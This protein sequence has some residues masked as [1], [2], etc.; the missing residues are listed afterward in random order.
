MRRRI[1]KAQDRLLAQGRAIT[2][3]TPAEEVHEL[4][5]D[6]KKLRY[7]LEC[8]GGLLPAAERKAFVKRLKE[9]QDN[10]GEHQDAAVHVAQ[11]HEAVDELPAGVPAD[12]VRRHRSADRAARSSPAGGP[13]T[14]SP[15]AS[16]G[17]TARRP[18]GRST[19][20]W[21]GPAG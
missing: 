18:T 6:A 11:L 17:T 14:S 15:S 3:D 7:L 13:G 4:R 5:K 16:P 19:T 21:T 9:L 1:D 2:P 10:L 8:F 12:D 20:C